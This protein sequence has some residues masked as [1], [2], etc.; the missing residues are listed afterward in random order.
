MTETTHADQTPAEPDLDHLRSLVDAVRR[1]VHLQ[2]GLDRAT[3][4]GAVAVMFAAVALLLWKTGWMAFGIFGIA[5]GVSSLAPLVAFGSAWLRDRDAVE[6]AQYLDR[7]HE[8]HDRLSTALALVHDGKT[9]AFT[10]AQLRDALDHTDDVDPGRAAPFRSPRDLSLLGAFLA[11]FA[12]LALVRPPTH[13]EPLPEPPP[14]KHDPVL[15]S[16]TLAMEQNRRVSQGLA[17]PVTPM[18]R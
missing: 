14:I 16:A 3:T 11:M 17:S 8:L 6:L 1:R 2:T 5:V 7:S 4:A 10:S 15:D 12:V 9:D 13:A 18:T